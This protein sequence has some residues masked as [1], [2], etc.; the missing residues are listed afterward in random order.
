MSGIKVLLAALT[1][2]SVLVL[3]ACGGSGG[4]ETQPPTQVETKDSDSDGVIDST[5]LCPNQVGPAS[6]NGCP[7]PP[8]DTDNDGIADV[9]DDCPQVFGVEQNNGCPLVVTTDSDFDGVLDDIDQ[10]PNE[11]GFSEYQGCQQTIPNDA[12][13]VA[14]DGDDNNPGTQTQPLKTFA[15]ADTLLAPGKTLI[16]KGGDYFEPLVISKDGTA[17]NPIIVRAANGETVNL[18][19]TVP[20]NNWTLH[21]GNIYKTNVKLELGDSYNQV[22]YN[23]QIMDIARWPNNV[24]NNRFTIDAHQINGG[25]GET[26]LADNLPADLVGGYMWYLGAHSGTSWTRKITAQS[27]GQIKFTP[28]D[29][30][31][32]PFD[33]HNPSIVRNGNRGRLFVFN[34]L[35]LLDHAREWYYDENSETLYFYAPDG[36]KPADGSVTVPVKLTAAELKGDYIQLQNLH[37][38]AANVITSGNYNSIVNNTII[39]GRERLDELDNTNAQITDG[40]ILVAGHHATISGN[41]LEHGSAVGVAVQAWSGRGVG[42][43]I[44]NN[45]IRYF[46][47]LGIHASPIRCG[48]DDVKIVKNTISHFGRDGIYYPGKNGEVAYNDVSQG[49]LINNDG[50]IF[51][52]VGND[53]QKNT[54]IHHNW[55]HDT[56]GPDYADGRAAG[57][58]LDNNSK[59]YLVDHNVVWNISWTGLQLNWAN[60]NIDMF[61]NTLWQVDEAMG[62]WVNGYEQKDNRV[63]NNLA[64]HADWL[65]GPEF[66]SQSNLINNSASIFEDADNHNFMPSSGSPLV[67]SAME[68]NGFHKTIV[69]SKADLGA[70]ERGGIRW[71]AGIHAVMDE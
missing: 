17:N 38:F 1:A 22:Y 45:V 26:I 50:G 58:Y 16:I 14:T 59:G 7:L 35:S 9:N 20:V 34:R 32:W 66:D 43:V 6:N 61:H 41:L 19:S 18:V 39:H 62:S 28:V 68:I 57:I 47:T 52:T 27:A 21:Q 3:S 63:Y 29:V 30:N 71:T 42:S 2:G 31:K 13:F 67:D 5:D 54:H 65:P 69:G 12:I 55:F 49:M 8:A 25:D 36:N 64:S 23:N 51:Y 53:E 4:G 48:A 11:K 37:V 15:K 46:N 60:W 10:C 70:Y 44:E 24:D 56:L 33:P 40:S